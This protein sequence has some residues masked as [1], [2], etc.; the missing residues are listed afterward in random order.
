MFEELDRTLM[1]FRRC[2]A[3]EGTQVFPFL[4]FWIDLP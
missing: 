3:V 1:L 4:R 2:A